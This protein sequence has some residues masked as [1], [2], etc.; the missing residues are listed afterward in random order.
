MLV[1]LVIMVTATSACGGMGCSGP[2]HYPITQVIVMGQTQIS[3]DHCNKLAETIRAMDT[4]KKLVAS[5]VV[6]R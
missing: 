1:T 6:S 3:V 2:V 5:C 4:T